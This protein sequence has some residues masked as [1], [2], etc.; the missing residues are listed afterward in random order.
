V[1]IE[2][3]RACRRAD[4]DE[5]ALALFQRLLKEAPQSGYVTE[6]NEELT[7]LRAK[8]DDPEGD[9]AQRLRKHLEDSKR[10]FNSGQFDAASKET[11][12]AYAVKPLPRMLFNI[13]QASRRAGHAEEAY[14]QYSQFL[15]E[16][17]QTPLKKETLG[18]LSELRTVAFRPP[19]YKRAW[20]WGV[21]G[22]AVAIIA[23]G[24]AG[25]SVALSPK[26]PATTNGTFGISFGLYQ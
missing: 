20:F 7:A 24:T 23:A 19:V 26:D 5:D 16:E 3:A 9:L 8:I 1:L 13:A 15:A 21:L 11:A 2:V 6:C 18:Y 12:L 14:V 4:L 25:V 17:Q 22:T 10:L